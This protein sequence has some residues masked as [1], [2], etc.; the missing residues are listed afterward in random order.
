MQ[1]KYGARL[2]LTLGLVFVFGYFGIDKLR[3]PLL[4]IGW[5]PLW[6]EGLLG[7]TR[8]TWLTVIGVLEIILAALILIPVQR[9]RLAG[10]LL[11]ALHLVGVLTQTG[12]N[13]IA[14][15]DV[16]LLC[17]ALALLALL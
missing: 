17:S 12:L 7:L 3:D 13:E 6:M 15:R 5:M 9:V 8:D 10:V 11:M 16:G 4:W 2:L 14:V 1:R